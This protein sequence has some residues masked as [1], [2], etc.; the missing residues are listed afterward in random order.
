MSKLTVLQ[1][2]DEGYITL[3]YT[4]GL[5]TYIYYTSVK[6]IS[7]KFR[8]YNDIS[9]IGAVDFYNISEEEREYIEKCVEHQMIPVEEL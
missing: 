5:S 2:N 9:I 1:T 8:N 4:V 7:M 3:Q 6:P